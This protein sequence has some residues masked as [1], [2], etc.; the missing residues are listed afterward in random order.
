LGHGTAG[1]TSLGGT[2]GGGSVGVSVASVG[3]GTA[4]GVDVG[5][6]RSRLV[7]DGRTIGTVRDMPSGTRVCT[8]TGRGG[9][10]DHLSPVGPIEVPCTGAA[11]MPPAP[12]GV[13]ADG[14]AWLPPTIQPTVT[15][16]GRPSA[17]MP[18]NMDFG[19]SLTPE[20]R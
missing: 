9:A 15:T 10:G 1:G 2:V 12:P 20:H 17:T 7:A 19:D 5:R 3:N 11:P 6:G 13:G 16:R 18:R 8:A 4:T 14:W